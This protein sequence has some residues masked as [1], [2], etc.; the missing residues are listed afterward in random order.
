MAKT[1]RFTDT[2][3]GDAFWQLIQQNK[4]EVL[5]IYLDALDELFLP[6]LVD[7]KSFKVRSIRVQNS[8]HNVPSDRLLY[9][10]ALFKNCEWLDLNHCRLGEWSK[11]IKPSSDWVDSFTHMDGL[12]GLNL[13]GNN[14]EKWT[15]DDVFKFCWSAK[16]LSYLDLSDNEFYLWLK[17]DPVGESRFS[18][19]LD[20]LDGS[21]IRAFNLSMSLGAEALNHACSD[22]FPSAK[23]GYFLATLES[24]D[25]SG[26]L[27][28][29]EHETPVLQDVLNAF[30]DEAAQKRSKLKTLSLRNNRL[31]N[32]SEDD[33]A[34]LA[35]ALCM[36]EKADLSGNDLGKWDD[37]TFDKFVEGLAKGKTL[38]TLRLHRCGMKPVLRHPRL[39]RLRAVVPNVITDPASSIAPK[40]RDIVATKPKLEQKKWPSF[41]KRCLQLFSTLSFFGAIAIPIFALMALLP[42][43]PIVIGLGIFSFLAVSIISFA[44]TRLVDDRPRLVRDA[45]NYFEPVNTPIDLFEEKVRLVER[46]RL[47]EHSASNS[48]FESPGSSLGAG[49]P[50]EAGL[51]EALTPN[52]AS[53]SDAATNGNGWSDSNETSPTTIIESTPEALAEVGQTARS[54]G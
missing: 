19:M 42:A 52:S 9:I 14:L 20:L 1:L 29:L 7:L 11:D 16:N 18:L 24:V 49:S 46:Q 37:A 53:P 23:F 21:K 44:L 33:A 10:K 32:F 39:E 43:T 35:H 5:D 4:S 25:L 15:Y 30:I 6:H 2:Q 40:A 45:R 48:S 34:T 12:K 51:S 41:L 8:L 17:N 27:P 36:V 26:T 31:D 50:N 47:D 22:K 28:Y 3:D 54:P 38:K 13:S